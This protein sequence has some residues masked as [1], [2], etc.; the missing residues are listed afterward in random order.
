MIYNFSTLAQ[1]YVFDAP[2]KFTPRKLQ[3]RPYLSTRCR[4]AMW[5]PPVVSLLQSC[6][7]DFCVGLCLSEDDERDCWLLALNK[8]NNT[9]IDCLFRVDL[10]HL[11]VRKFQILKEGYMTRPWSGI[12]NGEMKRKRVASRP[13]LPATGFI[14]L[15]PALL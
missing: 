3:T 6:A 15:I 7:Y 9:L 10:L 11:Y 14:V 13:T 8:G 2:D 4:P 1:T 12:M 5:S